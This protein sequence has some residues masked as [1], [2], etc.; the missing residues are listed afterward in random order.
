MDRNCR[1]RPYF[2]QFPPLEETDNKEAPWAWMEPGSLR[3]W[4]S[5]SHQHLSQVAATTTHLSLCRGPGLLLPPYAARAVGMHG[6]PHPKATSGPPHTQSQHQ[7]SCPWPLRTD[8]VTGPIAPHL[9]SVFSCSWAL[10]SSP[11]APPAP[12]APLASSLLLESAKHISTSG[13][14]CTSVCW[15]T[16]PQRESHAGLVPLPHSGL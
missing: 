3:G 9:S 2:P 11:P 10:I 4:P 12:P 13:P 6:G 15:S 5:P 8:D 7:S 14:F 1:Q 16:L